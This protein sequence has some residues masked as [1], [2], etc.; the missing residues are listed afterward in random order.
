VIRQPGAP[1]R[2]AAGAA[3]AAAASGT[4]PITAAKTASAAVHR[5]NRRT[6]DQPAHPRIRVI[7][8][9]ILGARMNGRDD[10]DDAS[11]ADRDGQRYA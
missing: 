10:R 1:T 8:D 7:A 3:V 6:T 9:T 4:H 11:P 5:A 2:F